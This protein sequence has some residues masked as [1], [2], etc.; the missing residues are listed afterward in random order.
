MKNSL[1]LLFISA[2]LFGC[3]ASKD[4]TDSS[5]SRKDTLNNPAS[6]VVEN[7]MYYT[8]TPYRYGG[9]SK[10]GMDC[11]GLIYVSFQQEGI[12]LPR[13]S[14][15]MSKEGRRLRLQEV[16]PGDLLFF[17]TNKNRNVINH[18]ALVVN[19]SGDYIR[20]IHS[21]SSSGV[22]VST[23]NQRYWK[24]AFVMARRVL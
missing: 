7:A 17:E 2:L 9:T 10:R 12:A 23:L 3:G 22:I 1:F 15:A 19:T 11:S 8:G 4:I 13:T 20:F 5:N 16:R 18:V 6:G 24:K 14:R 21:T